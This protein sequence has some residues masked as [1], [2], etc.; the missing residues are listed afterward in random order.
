MTAG[1]F[2]P[3]FAFALLFY[4]RLERVIEDER[5]HRFLEGVAAGVVGLIAVTAIQLGW[6]V[7]RSVPT[8]VFGA[9]IFVAALALLYRWRSKLAVPVVVLGSAAAGAVV[10]TPI[11]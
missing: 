9:A 11:R 1:I 6:N 10:F 3:A 2:L 5:L 8:L 7:S 4:E